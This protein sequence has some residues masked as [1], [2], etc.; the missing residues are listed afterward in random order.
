MRALIALTLL[1]L[2][3][4]VQ[5][6]IN[7]LNTASNGLLNTTPSFLPVE[8]AY[9]VAIDIDEPDTIRLN[10][11]MAP[12][13]YL[14]RNQFNYQA[15]IDNA[16]VATTISFPDG[17]KRHDEFFGE[18]EVY[19]DYADTLLHIKQTAPTIALSVRSQGCADA[20]L[21]YPPRDQYFT[22]DTQT[23]TVTE[24]AQA[25]AQRGTPTPPPNNS[26]NTLSI[27]YVLLLALAGGALLNLMPCVF[28][29][30]SLKALS[31]ATTPAHERHRQGLAYTAGVILSFVAVALILVALQAAGRAAGWGFQLQSPS[32]VIA[33]AYLFTAMGLGFSGLIEYGARWM[34]VGHQLTTDKSISGSF[35]TGVLAT[36]V[37][38]PCTGPFMGTA[39]GFAATQPTG[40]SIAVFTALGLG[41][42]LPLVILS[43]LP[44]LHQKMPKPG[45]WMDI[46]RRFMAFPL[47]ATALWLLWVAGR[48]TSIN[49]MTVALAGLLLLAM[50]LWLWRF[51]RWHRIPAL[52]ALA[53][54]IALGA[55][56]AN[57]PAITTDMNS[58]S[59]SPDRLNTLR[60]QGKAVFVDVTADWCL[61]CIVNEKTVLERDD[62]QALFQQNNIEYLVVDW[63][64]YDPAISAFLKQHGRNGIPFYLYYPS[65]AGSSPITLPQILS[66]SAILEA[67]KGQ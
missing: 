61:T 26:T 9:R 49:A 31:F 44:K 39:V 38:S 56:A 5:A 15:T 34:G 64:H 23:G 54:A 33:L 36:L 10:W 13:Y 4:T 30:L 17:L 27:A 57:S 11:Q 62:V 14:Y 41:M 52:L 60:Q 25:P 21:C 29:V 2:T 8:E 19:Y 1:A 58:G 37:A 65:G 50:G 18:V 63:T 47:Y 6:Q 40:V 32:F 51:S 66:K 16:P 20:G 46:F 7:P 59:W 28:P 55:Y 24:L 45:P 12:G 3:L 67:I 35:F 48:Q 53:G 43:Y 42:A 22:I